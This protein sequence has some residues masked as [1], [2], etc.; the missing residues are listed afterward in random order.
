MDH[1]VEERGGILGST[2]SYYAAQMLWRTSNTLY[3]CFIS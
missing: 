3:T 1:Q 2:A